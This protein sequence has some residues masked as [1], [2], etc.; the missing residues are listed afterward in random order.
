MMRCYRARDRLPYFKLN[1]AIHTALVAAAG[2][3]TLAWAH[4]AIQARMKHIRF[5]GNSGP[6]QWAG[7]VAEHQEMMRALRARDGAG[8]AEVLGQH[9]DRTFERVRGHL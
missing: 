9:L 2:N 1:Q 7:A 4:E 6:E 8:L 3:A 5:I